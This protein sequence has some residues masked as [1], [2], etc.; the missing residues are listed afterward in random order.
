MALFRRSYGI[1][2]E[3]GWPGAQWTLH[4]DDIAN[5]LIW[6]SEGERPTVE[7]IEAIS[8]EMWLAHAKD[9]GK[10]EVD[11]QAEVERQKV[12]TPGAGQAMVYLEKQ[13][14]A[15]EYMAKLQA[16]EDVSDET[17]YPML[18]ASVGLDTNWWDG[19]V[20]ETVE[21][22]A[23]TI[24]YTAQAWAAIAAQIETG[25]LQAKR[26]IMAAETIEAVEAAMIAKGWKVP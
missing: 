19:T 16:G 3:R 13:R 26:D 4:G 7:E 11:R 1:V 23:N 6:H 10:A 9:V 8:E 22:A 5:R 18:R 2:L 21:G 24:L 14:E 12:L 20:I 25:R 15:R 17:I